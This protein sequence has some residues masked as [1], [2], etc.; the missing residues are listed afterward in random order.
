MKK[1]FL[2]YNHQKPEL[3]CYVAELPSTNSKTMSK[4]FAIGRKTVMKSRIARSNIVILSTDTQMCEF[5]NDIL[6]EMS[7]MI[8]LA[9]F[10]SIFIAT[11]EK[12]LLDFCSKLQIDLVIADYWISNQNN[13]I[14]IDSAKQLYPDLLS[15]VLCSNSERAKDCLQNSDRDYFLKIPFDGAGLCKRIYWMLGNKL[16]NNRNK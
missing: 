11:C 10:K 6:T 2:K 4:F 14:V 7:E 12:E 1:L 8:G 3:Q 9:K 15:I 5:L 13:E 16:L